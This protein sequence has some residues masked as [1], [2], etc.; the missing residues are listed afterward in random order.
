MKKIMKKH[1]IDSSIILSYLLNDNPELYKKSRDFFDLVKLGKAKSY[2]EQA[3]FVK[4]ISSLEKDS[5]VPRAEIAKIL[6]N[7]LW[8]HGILNSEK[9]VLLHSLKLY[10]DCDLDIVDC[11]VV[12]KA[13]IGGHEIMAFNPLLKS[14]VELVDHESSTQ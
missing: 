11:L 12:A 14:Q 5:Q 7:L 1:L 8:Y 3:V 10:G 2:L 4:V 6:T 13:I 9:E